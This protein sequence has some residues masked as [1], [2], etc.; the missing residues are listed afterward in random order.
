MGALLPHSE[1]QTATLRH[2][3][4]DKRMG[5][6]LMHRVRKPLPESHLGLRESRTEVYFWKEDMLIL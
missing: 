5:D 6:P 4:M 1:M 3:A 2:R